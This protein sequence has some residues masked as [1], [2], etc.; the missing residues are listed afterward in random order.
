MLLLIL[1]GRSIRV[2][3]VVIGIRLEV[4]LFALFVRRLGIARLL[5]F[6]LSVEIATLSLYFTVKIFSF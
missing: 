2:V 1:G 4:L 5:E 3:A 6:F